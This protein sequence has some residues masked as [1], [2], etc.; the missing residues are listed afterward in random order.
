MLALRCFRSQKGNCPPE[1]KAQPGARLCIQHPCAANSPRDG[2]ELAANEHQ[3]KQGS[4][5]CT[6]Q[7][8]I[9]WGGTWR[10]M[11]EPGEQ[12]LRVDCEGLPTLVP[13]SHQIEMATAQSHP[14]LGSRCL[15]RG[16]CPG[17]SAPGC[18][19]ARAPE[20][21]IIR[22]VGKMFPRGDNW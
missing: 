15:C 6:Q 12:T 2:Y 21:L 5:R 9:S 16:T 11:L 4:W 20:P 13:L 14:R 10:W 17:Q 3:V 8:I 7:S 19:S 18:L 22:I 1:P